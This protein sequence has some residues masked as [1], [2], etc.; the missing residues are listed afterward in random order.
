MPS[1]AASAV[2]GFATNPGAEIMTDFINNGAIEG[3]NGE[4]V[5]VFGGDITGGG[6]FAD[7]VL[8]TGPYGPGN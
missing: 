5:L 3:G 7:N 8:F 2:F 6:S 4:N 1:V